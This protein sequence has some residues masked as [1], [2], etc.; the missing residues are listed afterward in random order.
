MCILL[1]CLFTKGYKRSG[2]A[3]AAIRQ[4]N[5][6]GLYG[7][8]TGTPHWR[9][10]AF[11]DVSATE[12]PQATSHILR[13]RGVIN[14]IADGGFRY[15]V[16]QFFAAIPLRPRPLQEG[17]EASDHDIAARD[18]YAAFAMG[19]FRPHRLCDA[20]GSRPLP[21]QGQPLRSV[22]VPRVPGDLYLELL[23][24]ETQLRDAWENEA[25]RLG[26]AAHEHFPWQL[27]ILDNMQGHALAYARASDRRHLVVQQTAAGETLAGR[28][29]LASDEDDD[30]TLPDLYDGVSDD[31]VDAP[32]FDA[33]DLS[34]EELDRALGSASV[35]QFAAAAVQ[36][37]RLP[38]V[39]GA[40]EG[41]GPEVTA[42]TNATPQI[43]QDLKGW[44]LAAADAVSSRG[45]L[46]AAP[47]EE[48]EILSLV[49]DGKRSVSLVYTK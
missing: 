2:I 48:T 26:P 21:R 15:V 43:R 10:L 1:S 46:P 17:E 28:L 31:D 8:I 19:T 36:A 47:V 33:A 25:G 12:H 5:D 9:E 29:Q 30:D 32:H 23:A 20:D 22:D 49:R 13:V 18:A 44:R 41:G 3:G 7:D 35:Q 16:P 42:F 45:R 11:Q 37:L 38:D 24:W 6:D 4:H 27:Q 34:A 40:A 14:G 39:I